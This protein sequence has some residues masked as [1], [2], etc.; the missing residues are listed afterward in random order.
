MDDPDDIRVV[1]G[2]RFMAGRTFKAGLSAVGLA[3]KSSG[4]Y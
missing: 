4:K 2:E 1:T 3:I